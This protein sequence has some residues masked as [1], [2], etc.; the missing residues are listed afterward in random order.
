MCN[1]IRPPPVGY[2]EKVMGNLHAIDN[3]NVNVDSDADVD[4]AALHNLPLNGDFLA[5]ETL[6]VR[7]LGRMINQQNDPGALIDRGIRHLVSFG[8][9]EIFSS[10]M[11]RRADRTSRYPTFARDREVMRTWLDSVQKTRD[12]ND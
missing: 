5:H 12:L 3:P 9:D 6:E 8:Y 7:R 1:N 11:A 4:T 10:F 2:P